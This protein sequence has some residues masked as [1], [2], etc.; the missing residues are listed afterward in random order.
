[1]IYITNADLFE[2]SLVAEKPNPDYGVYP[3]ERVEDADG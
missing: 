1:M 3:I 2:V